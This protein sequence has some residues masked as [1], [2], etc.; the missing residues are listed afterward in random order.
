MKKQ[1]SSPFIVF[2]PVIPDGITHDFVVLTNKKAQTAFSPF[3][4]TVLAT[5]R[6]AH[7]FLTLTNTKTRT[8]FVPFGLL[9][10]LTTLRVARRFL[11]LT[12]KQACRSSSSRWAQRDSNP[13]HPRCK[14]DALTN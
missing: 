2:V 14:R 5:L 8:V 1:V 11:T 7:R 12:D 9:I 3:G 10:V 13:R 6:V 4:L